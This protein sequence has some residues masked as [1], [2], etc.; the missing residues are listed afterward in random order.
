MQPVGGHTDRTRVQRCLIW[1]VDTGVNNVREQPLSAIERGS[2]MPF[3][4]TNLY[5]EHRKAYG[6]VRRRYSGIIQITPPP[7]RT[8]LISHNL[9][10]FSIEKCTE[11]SSMSVAQTTACVVW[12]LARPPKRP[13]QLAYHFGGLAVQPHEQQRRPTVR[14]AP[15]SDVQRSLE[16]S[17]SH[18]PPLQTARD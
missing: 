2:C 7:E 1:K 9:K 15:L 16:I 14:A 6:A 17:S 5:L 13:S 10:F 12:D 8:T 11:P 18:H 3:I 4:T